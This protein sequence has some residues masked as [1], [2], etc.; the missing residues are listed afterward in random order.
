MDDH[1]LAVDLGN[2]EVAH[3]CPGFSVTGERF[4]V[5]QPHLIDRGAVLRASEAGGGN[6]ISPEPVGAG[7]AKE[8]PLLPLLLCFVAEWVLS[9]S[10]ACS[11]QTAKK[12]LKGFME[13]IR[14]VMLDF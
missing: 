10:G 11:P 9:I 13:R 6:S 8:V 2:L 5:D 12:A 3:L 1:P 7:S 4:P 14:I